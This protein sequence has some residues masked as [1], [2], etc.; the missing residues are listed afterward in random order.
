[1]SLGGEIWSTKKVSYELDANEIASIRKAVLLWQER[2]AN[3]NAEGAILLMAI[4]DEAEKTGAKTYFCS[5]CSEG[6][7]S[8]PKEVLAHR[9]KHHK[10]SA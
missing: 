3:E 9:E 2:N 7:F 8:S 5:A 10:L 4:L 1:M 6:P